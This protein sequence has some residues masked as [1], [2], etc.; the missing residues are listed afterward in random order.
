ATVTIDY[1]Q[2]APVAENDR[3]VGPLNTAVSVD[4]LANDS[5]PE[6]DLDPTTVKLLDPTDGSEVTTVTVAGE[7]EWVVDPDTGIVTF[8]PEAG[9]TADPTPVDYVVSDITG[10][11]SNLATIV[12]D[13]PPSAPVAVDDS[14]SGI[15]GSL[16]M[17]DI[18]GND[19]DLD[20][21]LDPTTVKLL[22]PTD[23]SEVT[24]LTITG[25]GEW[26]VDPDTGI[27]TFT[28]EAGF[29]DDPTPVDYVVSDT[30][31]LTS[32]PATVTIDYPQ[33]APVAE[34]DS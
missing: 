19:T 15:S 34:N 8:T 22:D 23:G 28:P 33:T 30:T 29:T 32:D 16:V 26:V 24:T 11:Q 4:I 27:V 1:P 25:E 13:Y 10:E 7:G 20:G 2:T 18:L 14:E 31:G 3:G 12:V 17:V 9:F 21:D 6:D 5:D